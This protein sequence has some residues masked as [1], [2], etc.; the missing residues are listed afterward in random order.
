LI[1]VDSAEGI[2]VDQAYGTTKDGPKD[3]GAVLFSRQGLDGT[4]E[5]TIQ[6]SWAGEGSLGGGYLGIFGFMSVSSFLTSFCDT[7][8]V[9][10]TTMTQA[11]L[12]QLAH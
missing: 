7:H 9:S 2:T 6:V 11:S 1:S 12:L 3:D 8:L 5:H 10:D 4:K